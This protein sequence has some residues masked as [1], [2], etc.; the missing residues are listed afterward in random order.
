MSAG[1]ASQAPAPVSCVG[2]RRQLHPLPRL[3]TSG[4][5]TRRAGIP[6]YGVM[7]VFMKDSDQF[8]HGLNE[9]VRVREFFGAQEY[10]KVLLTRLAGR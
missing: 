9:R 5:H 6:T 4:L 8:A 3:T 2:P 1:T 7:G 10:W